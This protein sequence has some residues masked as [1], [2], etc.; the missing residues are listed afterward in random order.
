MLTMAD[1]ARKAGVGRS[2]VSHVL[3]KHLDENVRIPEATRQRVLDAA[4]EL[5]YRPNALAR[6]V[7][8]G[9]SR[10]IGYLVN[11][12]HYEPYWKTLIG[13][14][15]EAEQEGFTLKLLSVTSETF[16]ERIRQCIE[17]RLGGLIVRVS[18]DKSVLF[19]EAN[20][21]RIPFVMVDE[22]VP[23]P[24]GVRI[25]TD[26]ALG[27]RAAISHL[28]E[29]GHRKIGFISSGFFHTP[30]E[31]IQTREELF[32]QEM[33]VRGLDVPKGFVTRETM[34]VYG[35]KAELRLDASTVRDAT[36]ALLEHPGGRPTAIF[37]WRDETALMAMRA[38]RLH[39]L[40][41]PE[42]ISLVGFSD[43]NATRL[44]DPP[45]TTCTSPWEEMGRTALR[46]LVGGLGGEFDPSPQTILIPS[47]LVVRQS[48]GPCPE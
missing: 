35:P 9:K 29:L 25:A 21:A 19:E 26:D 44:S 34:S 31:I 24:F 38:C 48:S 13:S 12:P 16:A 23:Q 22:S 41:V 36:N 43:I 5:G 6:S 17:L 14:L 47:G 32:R 20:A 33:A 39:G 27:C 1:V 18:Q 28:M 11:D 4:R 3:G 30:L 40:R 7:R 42:D 2:T 46:H 45:L 8:S 10:M 37:C 15:A